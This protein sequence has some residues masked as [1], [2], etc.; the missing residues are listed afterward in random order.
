ML[1]EPTSSVMSLRV[2]VTVMGLILISSV[3]FIIATEPDFQEPRPG[4]LKPPR[5]TLLLRTVEAACIYIFSLEYLAR[6]C[7]VW[8]VRPYLRRPI[9]PF[10]LVD[11][12]PDNAAT[13]LSPLFQDQP[14]HPPVP[15]TPHGA[16]DHAPVR[17]R[18][19]VTEFFFNVGCASIVGGLGGELGL[20]GSHR[21]DPSGLS[22]VG[23]AVK[24]FPEARDGGARR[25]WRYLSAPMNLIDFVAIMPFYVELVSG[26]GGGGLAVLRILRLARVFRL[27]K[28]GQLNEGV[29]L[30]SNVVRKSY[31]SLKLL[32][33]FAL[34]GC[35]LF[36]SIIHLC[37]QGTWHG[38]EATGDDRGHRGRG[39][40]MRPDKF[41]TGMERTPFMSIPRS[42]WWVMVTATTVGYG[43]MY[44]TTALGKVVASVTMLSGVLVLALPITIISQN[45]T[46]EYA[47]L[48]EEKARA[49]ERREEARRLRE[50]KEALI[51]KGGE[52]DF[53]TGR[54]G[55]R[56]SSASFDLGADDFRAHC[57]H[58]V[59]FTAAAAKG[60][61][62]ATGDR[63]SLTTK[64]N[65]EKPAGGGGAAADVSGR[66]RSLPHFQSALAA[67]PPSAN[68]PSPHLS[69]A[70][71]SSNSSVRAYKGAL[72]LRLERHL[73]M[74]HRGSRVLLLLE[75]LVKKQCCS[76]A[77]AVSIT[78]EVLGIMSRAGGRGPGES[79]GEGGGKGKGG[80]VKGG[81]GGGS[82][83]A[84]AFNCAEVDTAVQVVL[85][86]FKRMFK[87]HGPVVPPTPHTGSFVRGLGSPGGVGGVGCEEG[88]GF[89]AVALHVEAGRPAQ[90][91]SE[92]EEHDLRHAFLALVLKAIPPVGP[93]IPAN[94][95]TKG[96][97]AG[98]PARRPSDQKR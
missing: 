6:A 71:Q 90:W 34:I 65:P 29:T 46:T 55:L 44:P 11:A 9:V 89:D 19:S 47:A 17:P 48:E 78:R 54:G 61:A 43:D 3:G 2:A 93:V 87:A 53:S 32:C 67:N 23:E 92:D 38:P 16:D 91:P 82:T 50:R 31:P 59:A 18:G 21:R 77:A 60:A 57:Q 56:R 41:G 13:G 14:E 97:K 94:G 1:D 69:A 76:E 49:L 81:G 88:A 28:F 26:E 51:D 42:M 37:E 27:F 8:A 20:T 84:A 15:P 25:T 95:S 40:W 63:E 39:V 22:A 58:D 12:S 74:L 98:T 96:G 5:E 36:G 72:T 33:F 24:D 35:V 45:F 83:D 86:W 70:G 52:D 10:T 64:V 80:K 7:T 68:P 75:A 62:G 85:L 4:H 66:R 30:L 73:E 79:G